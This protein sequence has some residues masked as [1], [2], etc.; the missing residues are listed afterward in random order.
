MKT[1]V[2]V[3]AML[4]SG[5]NSAQG[6]VAKVTGTIERVLTD[7]RSYGGCMML[8]PTIKPLSEYGLTCRNNYFTMDCMNETGQPGGRAQ[9]NLNLQQ[10]QLALVTG[11]KVLIVVNDAITI[12][13]N[14]YAGRIELYSQQP[15]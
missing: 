7:T 1:I 2:I 4:L 10:A 15:E 6:A 9:A 8:A 5:I 12:N 13:G 14:C 11:N 3:T